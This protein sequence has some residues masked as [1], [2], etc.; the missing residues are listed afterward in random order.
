MKFVFASDSFKGSLTGEK[1]NEILSVYAKRA[2]GECECV[3]LLIAD[4][5][6]G[7]I[8]A[9]IGRKNG[10][11]VYLTAKN[12]LGEIISTRYGVFDDTALV[13]M[14]E[15]SGLPL[16]AP[17][18]RSARKTSTFGTGELIRHAVESG[19]KKIYVTLGGSA[20]NDGG[21]GALTALGYRFLDENGNVLKGTGEELGRVRKIDGSNALDFSKVEV[22]LLCDVSNPL[23][24]ENGATYTYGRQKGATEADL[25]FLESG[26]ENFARVAQEFCGKTLDVA[27][28]GAAGGI[29]GA[30]YAF[31]N[32]EIRSGIETVL[33]LCEFDNALCGADFVITGEGRVDFQS[34]NGKVIDGILRRAKKACVPV[35][36][37]AG[38]LGEGAELLF[39]KGL[40]AAFAIVNRPMGLETAMEN[41]QE[42]YEKTAENVFRLIKSVRK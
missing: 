35:V 23:L 33:D 13:C 30:L 24:G 40:A 2:F 22:R 29:G 11:N 4:G 34:A 39:D 41:A 28:G 7:T 25:A 42:L 37:I 17:S 6:E 8:E 26:M 12:P 21:M 16:L 9:V 38:S 18:A 10:K 5:G 20:T 19:Y 1:I 31:L 27:G 3:P 36:A 14:S 32:A 15:I